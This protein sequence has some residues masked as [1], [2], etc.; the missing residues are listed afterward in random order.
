[1]AVAGALLTM[2]CSDVRW[3]S[4]STVSAPGPGAITLERV[5]R[6][7]SAKMP[8]HRRSSRSRDPRHLDAAHMIATVTPKRPHYFVFAA[9]HSLARLTSSAMPRPR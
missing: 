1:M 3:V 4:I 6:D 5:H 8:Y 2:G 9:I 7:A